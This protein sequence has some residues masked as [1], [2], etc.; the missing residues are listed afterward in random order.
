MGLGSRFTKKIE[1][2]ILEVFIIIELLL[3]LLVSFSAVSTYFFSAYLEVISIYI[4]TLTCLTGLL[5]GM[6]I[7]LAMR[8][9]DSFE[10]FK[11]NV[12]NI[13]EKDYYGSLVGGLFFVFVGLPYI[14]LSFTPFILGA[15]NFLMAVV[16][17]YFFK[18]K[19]HNEYHKSLGFLALLF[20]FIIACGAYAAPRI[21]QYGEQLNY[22]DKIIY[23]KQSLYQKIVVTNWKEDYWL[24]LND[25][26]QFSSF[27]EPL[28]H[29]VLVHP[30]M[31]TLQEP[32]EILILGGGDGCAARELLKYPNVK[33][34]TLVDL[35]KELTDMFRK[36]AYLREINKESL[37]DP[38]VKVLNQDGFQFLEEDASFYDLIIVDLPDPRTVE[39][40]RLYSSAFYTLCYLKLRPKGGMISQSGSPYYTANAFRCIE[41]TMGSVGF[42]TLPIHNQI[43]TMGEW[44]WTIGTKEKLSAKEIKNKMKYYYND[45]IPTQWYQKESIDLIGSFGK[46]YFRKSKDSIRLNTIH[47]PVL[48]HYYNEGKWDVY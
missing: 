27:D 30:I 11:F 37:L 3:S 8:L 44:G 39:L 6:E 29:E 10:D 14:G 25:H 22:Q 15:I 24:Y 38:K 4:Y 41:K 7:P 45:N 48:Y 19:R 43:L 35:D 2:N 28:Y 40:S 33:Q 12:A 36:E 13:L 42:S 17:W 5:I 20:A 23:Q 9:N 21:I 32:K 46:A 16:L 47:D 34:I 1:R 26:L 18:N 31:Q